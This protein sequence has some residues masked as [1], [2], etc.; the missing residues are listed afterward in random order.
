MLAKHAL[1]ENVWTG[2]TFRFPGELPPTDGT[3]LVTDRNM[4]ILFP[5]LE[6]WTED[7]RTCPP[8]IAV[9]EK[10]MAVSIWCRVRVS[11]AAHEAGVETPPDFR[12]RGHGTRAVAAWARAV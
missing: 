1:V 10:E 3:V 2:P 6:E 8:V 7:V 4:D 11:A 12:G 5:H 9:V